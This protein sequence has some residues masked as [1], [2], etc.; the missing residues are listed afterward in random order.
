M[1]AADAANLDEAASQTLYR[2]ATA[3]AIDEALG[4]YRWG[5]ADG[6]VQFTADAR[7]ALCWHGA[8]RGAIGDVFEVCED[9]PDSAE[10]SDPSVL[11]MRRDV[12]GLARA[13]S[14]NKD[15]AIED[16]EV[17]VASG[18]DSYQVEQRREWVQRLRADEPVS[19]IFD[20]ATLEALLQQ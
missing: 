11:A 4:L 17:F 12:R 2:L 7:M 10:A 16:F 1:D 13:L 8:L 5:T 18:Y 14:G 20:E 9:L 19:A 15:G 6:A 3:N